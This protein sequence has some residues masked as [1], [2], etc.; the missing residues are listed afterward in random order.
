VLANPDTS[1]KAQPRQM[2]VNVTGALPYGVTAK[3]LIPGGDRA[4]RPPAAVVGQHHRVTAARP[5]ASCP[6]DGRMTVCNMSIEAGARAGSSLRTTPTFQLSGRPPARHHAARTGRRRWTY[7][8]F[9]ADRLGRVFRPGSH[10]GRGRP[11]AVRHLGPPTR[12]RRP[13]WPRRYRNPDAMDDPGARAT[14]QRALTYMDLAPGT[15]LTDISVNTVFL[16][17]C[18]NRPARGPA[19]R[20]RRAARAGLWPTVSACWSCRARWDVKAASRTGGPG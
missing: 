11:D 5:C 3:D 9:A 7:W 16:G 18:T 17:S 6:L 1:R 20:G 8:R 15:P 4:D 10:P 14:A 19:G 13:R 2:A 12:R